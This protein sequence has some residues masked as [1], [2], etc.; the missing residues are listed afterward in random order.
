M[1]PNLFIEV[2]YHGGEREGQAHHLAGIQHMAVEHEG[3]QQRQ[4]L[5]TQPDQRAVQGSEFRNRE[6][7]EHLHTAET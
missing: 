5:A 4:H 7:N 1:E 6:E 3:Q 2:G